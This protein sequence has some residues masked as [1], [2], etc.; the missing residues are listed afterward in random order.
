MQLP[1]FQKKQALPQGK[2]NLDLRPR[3][4]R[5]APITD[6]RTVNIRYPLI[7]PYAFAHLYWDQ[8]NQELAYDVEQPVLDDT[9]KEI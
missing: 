2:F 3:L 4:I 8:K 1:F 6:Y 5:I 7:P 9:E